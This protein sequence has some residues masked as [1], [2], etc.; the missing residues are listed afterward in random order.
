MNIVPRLNLNRHPKDCD[1][2]SLVNALNMKVSHDESCLTNEESIKENTFIHSFLN[3]Y[4]SNVA[5]KIV[6][7]ISCNNE[8][9]IIVKPFNTTIYS[10][11]FRYQEAINNNI[12]AIYCAY[13]GVNNSNTNRFKYSGGLI[14]GVYTYNVENS[15]VIAITEYNVVNTK[16]PLR[17]INLGNFNNP[18][19]YNDSQLSNAKLSISP[20]VKL[21]N[22]NNLNYV[23]GS[24]YKGWYYLFIRYKINT[25]DYTQWY[26]I[27]VPIY[28]DTLEHYQILRY[29]Y[30]RDTK[31]PINSLNNIIVPPMPDSGYGAGCSDHFSNTSDIAKETFKIDLYFNTNVDYDK[32]QI[33]LICTSKSY[34]KAFRTSDIFLNNNYI[35][36][37]NNKSQ[38]YIL[39]N[40]SLITYNVDDLITDNFNYFNIKN[41]NNYQN[42]LYVSNYLEDNANNSNI[43]QSIVDAINVNIF[44]RN[45]ADYGLVYDTAIIRGDGKSINQYDTYSTTV[46]PLHIYLKVSEETLITI[47]ATGH[48][49]KTAKAGQFYITSNNSNFAFAYIELREPGASGT[50][51]ITNYGKSP[52][53]TYLYLTIPDNQGNPVTHTLID[54]LFLAMDGGVRYINTNT[55]FNERKKESCLIPGEIYNFFI[56]FVNDYGHATNGYKLQNKTIWDTFDNVGVEI[57]PIPFNIKIGSTIIQYIAAMSVNENVAVEEISIEQSI[58]VN[59]NNIKFYKQFTNTTLLDRVPT[60]DEAYVIK[61]FIQQFSSYGNVKFLSTKWYQISYGPGEDNFHLF[62]NNNGDRLF[63]V[64]TV[65]SFTSGWDGFPNEVED[66]KTYNIHKLLRVNLNNIEIPVEYSGYYI[67]YEQFESQRRVTGLL[68]R[69]DF[70]SQDYI[71]QGA[72]IDQPRQTLNTLKSDKMFFYSSVYDISDNIKLDYNI[73]RIESINPF[74]T[75][76]IPEWDYFQLNNIFGFNHDMNKPQIESYG[77]Y[78]QKT[79]AIPDYKIAVADSAADNRMGL[80]T[81]LEIDDAY[82][83]FPNYVPTISYG[84]TVGIK[85]YRVTLL[86]TT[87]DVYM[88]NSKKLIK[89][90]DVVY[91]IPA[92]P[93]NYKYSKVINS[94]YNGHYT[95]DGIPIYENRGVSFNTT[96]NKVTTFNTNIEYYKSEATIDNPHSYENDNPFL[97]YL[98]IPI[99]MDSFLESKSFKS[100]PKGIIYAVKYN[101]AVGDKLPTGAKFAKGCMVTPVNT[102]DLFENKQSNSDQFNPKTYSNFRTDLV[103]IEQF[104]KTLRRSSV[105]QDESRVNGWRSFPIE[106]YKNITENKGKITNI[107]GIGTLILV[108]TEHSLFM[109]N[110]DNTLRT[111]DRDIQLIQP[112]AFDVQYKEVFTSDKGYGGLQDDKSWIIDDFGYMF[113]SVDT[114]RIYL[115]DNNQLNNIDEDILQWLKKYKPFNIRMANDKENNRILIKFDYKILDVIKHTVVSYNYKVKTFV[116]QH[117]YYFDQAFNTKVGLY[118]QCDNNHNGC[119]LHSFNYKNNVY[120]VFDNV[121]GSFGIPVIKQSKINIIVNNNFATVKFI[122]F[123][124]YKLAKYISDLALDLTILPVEGNIEPFAGNSVTI[125]NNMTNTGLLNINVNAE[126]VKNIFAN[127]DKPYWDL[128]VWNF[129]YLRNRIKELPDGLSA[130]EMSRI[131]GNY[132]IIEFVF[133]NA[134]GRRVEFEELNYNISEN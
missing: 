77:G 118:L 47:T 9:V 107:I 112:D 17:T 11:I 68:T 40:K 43:N 20:E 124:S 113:Y 104:D 132:F 116:S 85:L 14:K 131:F 119:S 58:I 101:A 33:G 10:D 88:S 84:F 22:V 15:L 51:V 121:I 25:V 103:S 44:K 106:G 67:S 49:T 59:I 36:I 80:G 8:L 52:S 28:V 66:F 62:I 86:N 65:E 38:Q 133:D 5:Y 31:F 89:L 127:F 30:N 16:I 27:G 19:V 73:M 83:L 56:H 74:K 53:Q 12:E 63:K 96:T 50:V 6:G 117:S 87:R 75:N 114:N 82:N 23:S 129:S 122:E 95:Y 37:D 13:G 102:I 108:H 78:V 18:T 105:I 79:Y 123:I 128:G 7:I 54:T 81:A 92:Q 130:N 93:I 41:I 4:Y 94:G 120:G 1:N 90:T 61:T 76:D 57:I 111:Q 98:Q 69:N 115:F 126:V 48:T 64:P 134:D 46:V 55:N 34:V 45:I 42:R 110:G 71:N 91:R 60:I 3:T 125:Y 2:L 24:A 35:I 100:A 109:F 39:D 70:R 99:C 97:A 29:C 21:P 72:V 32:Y 26:S